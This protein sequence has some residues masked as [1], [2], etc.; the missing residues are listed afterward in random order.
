MR[1]ASSYGLSSSSLTPSIQSTRLSLIT[2]EKRLSIRSVAATTI[3]P[4]HYG[5]VEMNWNHS[6]CY[7]S[8]TL[9]LASSRSTRSSM[10]H[11]SSMS[12]DQQSST[13][14]EVS[15]THQHQQEM[16]TFRSTSAR[17]I[18]WWRGFT[19]SPLGI[20]IPTQTSITT[21]QQCYTTIPP[22]QSDAFQMNSGS[23]ACLLFSP[24]NRRFP[25][26]TG[27]STAVLYSSETTM[28]RPE[29]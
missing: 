7:L 4:L 3:L 18:R 29:V 16:G 8:M 26:S 10:R 13:T 9:R 22:I 6:S 11:C 15:R 5:Q 21:T 24:G 28:T 2:S 23:S 19:M 25:P 14:R 17:R 20:T 27:L 1:R 12:L